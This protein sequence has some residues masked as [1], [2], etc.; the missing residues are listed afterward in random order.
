MTNRLGE[1]G[2][3]GIYVAGDSSF[4]VQFII[5]AAAEG[6]KAAVSINK[7]LQKEELAKRK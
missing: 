5:V 2:V 7:Q 4:D 1:T 6:A 3:D